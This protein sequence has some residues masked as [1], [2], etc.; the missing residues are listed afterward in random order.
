MKNKSSKKK[1]GFLIQKTFY[2]LYLPLGQKSTLAG[3]CRFKK[4]EFPAANKKPLK[5]NR[6]NCSKTNKNRP[7]LPETFLGLGETSTKLGRPG[8]ISGQ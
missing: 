3:L 2:Y 4:K 7:D 8:M 5:S 1:K 6:R